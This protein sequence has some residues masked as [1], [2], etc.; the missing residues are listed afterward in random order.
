MQ[1]DEVRTMEKLPSFDLDF[2]KLGLQDVLY[3]PKSD[4][5]YTPNTN[6]KVSINAADSTMEGGE[7]EDES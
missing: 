2:V 5:V 7:T 1:V 6:K 4:E 3:F